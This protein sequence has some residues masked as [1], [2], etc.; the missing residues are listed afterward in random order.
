MLEDSALEAEMARRALAGSQDVELF[1]DGAELLERLEKG[2]PDVVILDWNLPGLTG[3]DVCRAIRARYDEVT[4]PILLLTV[5]GRKEDILEALAGGASDY[6]T[7]PYD[8]LELVARVGTLV[9]TSRLQ[10]AQARR[11]RQLALSSD[12]GAAMTRG[13][14]LRE[15][16]HHC[17]SAIE[18]HLEASLVEVWTHDANGESLAASTDERGRLPASFIAQLTTAQKR[19]CMD[20]QEVGGH[21][22]L[23]GV[24][25][26]RCGFV[27][28]PLLERSQSVGLVTI[29][30]RS[31]V[32]EAS[33]IF[34]SVADLL[35]LGISRAKFEEERQGLLERERNAR[36]DAEA[37][38]RSKDEFLAMVSHELRTPLN[39]ITGWTAMLLEGGLDGD[40][41]K[42][43]LTIIDR[44]ARAQTQLIDDLLDVSRIISGRLR[45]NVGNIDIASVSEMAV[46]S[47]RLA[48][49]AKGVTLDAHIEAPKGIVTG[50]AERIQQVIW[51][52]LNNAIKFTNKGGSVALA[53]NGEGDTLR[54]RVDDTGQGV[55][56]KFLPYIFER[57]KQQD[58]TTT[59][60]KGGLGLGLAIVRHLV[61]LH[62]GTIEA[63]SEGLGKGASF[64][65]QLPMKAK[66]AASAERSN[67][68]S[69]RPQ[70]DRPRELE[71][72]RV[73]VVD[74]EPDAR[75]LVRTLL[76]ACR[77]QV[78]TAGSAAEA[79]SIATSA[80]LDIIVSDIAM[81]DEDGISFIKRVRALPREEGGRIPAVAL[82][83]YARL[84]DRT[85]ALR[86]GFNSHIAKPVD[87]SELLAVL[88]SLAPSQR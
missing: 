28:L 2:P 70:F 47:V 31:K 48:A 20:A 80:K 25:P 32:K 11:A 46:E 22:V 59:R 84:E 74:D 88:L 7:K 75:D 69:L 50:D 26:A 54:I 27:A 23:R 78:T 52:L 86:A 3:L 19:V 29:F 44:N 60:A 53:V 61:E 71:G 8:V 37:A 72:L 57:F 77:L 24:A 56:P 12:I 35:A 40:R 65:V 39:A 41:A 49:E 16:A 45:L 73:L 66:E 58:G 1:T 81:P 63:L 85:R 33:T 79:F 42:R 68:V 87:P 43:A 13:T 9:R 18:I 15:I 5:Q 10:H 36:A 21:P 6:V 55:D 82:T 64:V 4:L 67:A 17:A 34:A 30:T 38:N 76:E 51:N 62:G 83:A 14:S